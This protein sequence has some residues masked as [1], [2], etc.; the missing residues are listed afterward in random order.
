MNNIRN[1]N[2]SVNPDE[3]CGEYSGYAS[4]YVDESGELPSMIYS[5]NFSDVSDVNLSN[6]NH[7]NDEI[8]DDEQLVSDKN[9]GENYISEEDDLPCDAVNLADDISEEVLLFHSNL[10]DD[11]V[12]NDNI[13]ENDEQG[14]MVIDEGS[15]T[16]SFE[17]SLNYK[18][19]MG[20]YQKVYKEGN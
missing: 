17:D 7:E 13:V 16:I 14:V 5:I 19:K 9:I 20:D 4:E 3:F 15:V 6:V 1:D 2:D 12:S 11:T 18:L 10:E 8:L